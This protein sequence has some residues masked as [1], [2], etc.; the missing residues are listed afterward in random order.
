MTTCAA[1][2]TEFRP[3]RSTARYCG[4]RCRKA[5]SRG[6]TG[7]RLHSFLSVTG[8]TPSSRPS[9][10]SH[11]TLTSP[12]RRELKRLDRRIV[13][14]EKWPNMFRIRLPDGALSVMV[15]LTRAKDALLD[16]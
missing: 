5:A 3:R 8:H 12:V 7:G 11:V 6:V 13:P 1:C 16:Y 9:K 4:A 2:K 15:N 14:D 10:P